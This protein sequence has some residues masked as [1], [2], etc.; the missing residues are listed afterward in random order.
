M[1]DAKLFHGV[2]ICPIINIGWIDC[3]SATMS[4]DENNIH[5]F[6]FSCCDDIR[7]PSKWGADFQLFCVLQK[8][9]VVNARPANDSDFNHL[10]YEKVLLLNSFGV[11]KINLQFSVKQ[12]FFF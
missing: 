7:S 4:G 11:K 10:K 12:L 6:E 3:M 5:T 2:N 1:G 9:M 8:L